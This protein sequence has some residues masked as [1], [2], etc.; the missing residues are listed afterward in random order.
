MNDTRYDLTTRCGAIL[1]W[2]AVIEIG[3]MVMCYG[4]ASSMADPYAGVGVLSPGLRVMAAISVLAL[5]VGIGCLAADTPKPDQAPRTS[6]RVAR[7][8]HLL[9][10]IPGAWFWLHA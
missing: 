9:L 6:F 8:P 7:P 1:A 10:C 4:D 3:A 5:A 2:I